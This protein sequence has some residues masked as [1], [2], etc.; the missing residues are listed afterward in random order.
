MRSSSLIELPSVWIFC[1]GPLT[2]SMLVWGL[3]LTMMVVSVIELKTEVCAI[4]CGALFAGG[5]L[6]CESLWAMSKTTSLA[7]L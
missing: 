6:T 5:K 1:D 2:V 4:N 7:L 3:L